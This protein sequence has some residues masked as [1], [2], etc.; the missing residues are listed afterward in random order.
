MFVYNSAGLV[1]NGSYWTTA[2]LK[3]MLVDPSYTPDRDHVFVSSIGNSEISV[4]GY[5]RGFNTPGRK[6]LS[7]TT[8]RIDTTNNRVTYGADNPTWSSFGAAGPNAAVI[9]E[10]KTSD[11][12]SLLIAYCDTASVN[13]GGGG[14]YSVVWSGGSC[15]AQTF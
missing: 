11:N 13:T 5:S 14:S 9:I 7:N 2:T 10:Q 3:V 15:F 4:S 8:V 6:T 1:V 12:D